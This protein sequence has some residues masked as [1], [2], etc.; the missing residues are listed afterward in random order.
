MS[1]PLSDDIDS[2]LEVWDVRRHYVAKYALP[3]YDGN[4]VAAIWDDDN[5]IVACY[6]NGGLVQID[7]ESRVSPRTI[8]LETIPR[9][10]VAWSVKNELAYAIDRFKL[11]EVPFDDV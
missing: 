4:A 11:G 9:Q 2:S 1:I 10:V 6:Q 8:P 3:G 7:L 5:S